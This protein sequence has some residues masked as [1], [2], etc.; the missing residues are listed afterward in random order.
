M[1]RSYALICLYSR[2][3]RTIGKQ[4]ASP[5]TRSALVALARGTGLPTTSPA[6]PQPLG[7]TARG[8]HTLREHGSPARDNNLGLGVRDAA[9]RR[10]ATSRCS[11]HHAVDGRDELNPIVLP[12]HKAHAC[13][14][15]QAGGRRGR[16]RG[17]ATRR[18]HATNEARRARTSA[19]A[20]RQWPC[21][22]TER[23]PLS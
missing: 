13:A 2:R 23:R 9:P 7:A 12:P 14:A 16:R 15:Q 18:E 21:P 6:N 1:E 11:D 5:A 3:R 17:R 20:H 10:L 19:A 22:S 4:T 8:R